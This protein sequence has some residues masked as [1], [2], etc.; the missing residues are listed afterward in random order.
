MLWF[1]GELIC[2]YRLGGLGTVRADSA[3]TSVLA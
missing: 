1:D 2:G 3:I